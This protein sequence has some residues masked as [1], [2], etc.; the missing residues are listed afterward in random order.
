[1]ESSELND[2]DKRGDYIAELGWSRKISKDVLGV[3]PNMT[4][5]PFSD[6]E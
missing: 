5:L 4:R 1:V 2:V 3:T 6:I